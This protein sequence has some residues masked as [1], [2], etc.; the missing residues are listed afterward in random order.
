MNFDTVK[1]AGEYGREKEKVYEK[2]IR[3]YHHDQRLAP[4]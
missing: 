1:A 4:G 3:F 2:N